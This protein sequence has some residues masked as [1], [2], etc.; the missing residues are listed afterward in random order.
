MNLDDLKEIRM[1]YPMTL[2]EVFALLPEYA[3]ESIA[4]TYKSWVHEFFHHVGVF[5]NVRRVN[6]E[7]LQWDKFCRENE[8]DANDFMIET[9]FYQKQWEAFHERNGMGIHL[10]RVRE[11]QAAIS[12]M[13]YGIDYVIEQSLADVVFAREYSREILPKPPKK[14]FMDRNSL[15]EIW[16]NGYVNNAS[17]TVR[18]LR[19]MPYAEYLK[20]PHWRNVRDAMIMFYGCR[21]Q[22]RKCDM[23]GDSGYGGAE[24]TIHVHHLTYENRGNERFKDLTLLC[25]RC[26]KMEHGIAI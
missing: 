25:D 24:S 9:P 1:Y 2:N 21:C 17:S 16:F 26:H 18:E 22:G 10:K 11:V 8:C 3:E 4:D 19:G 5:T 15:D 23:M 14:A 12:A 7:R 20:T 6:Y 13:V